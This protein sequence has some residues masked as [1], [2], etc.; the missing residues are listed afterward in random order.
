MSPARPQSRRIRILRDEVSRKIAAGEVID[1]PFSIVRELLDNAIDSGAKAIDVHIEAGGLGRVRV[2]DDGAGMDREDLALCWKP[3]ATSKIET[4]D[5]LLRVSSLGFRGEALSS[6]AVCSRL[7]I[8]SSQGGEEPA[9]R[10]EVQGGQG[11]APQPCQG[12]KGTVV[13]VAELF[14]NYPA[15]KKFLR[16]ASAESGLC[17]SIFIDRAIAF[18]AVAFRLYTDGDLK[19]SLPV[20]P[21]SE[22]IALAYSQF[23]DARGL[24]EGAEEG[25]G[26]RVRVVAGRPDLRRRDRKLLQC[27]VNGRRVSEFSLLQA[28]EYGFAGFIP[29]GWYPVAFIFVEIDPDLIDFNIHPAK[30]EVRFRN[31]PDFHKAVV[32]AVKR[33]VVPEGEPPIVIPARKAGIEFAPQSQRA[34]SL[35]LP[36]SPEGLPPSSSTGIRFLGQVFGVFLV[37]ELPG[38]LLVIDQHAAHERVIFE[39]LMARS[40]VLQEMLFPLVFDVSFEEEERLLG[41]LRD[42]EDLGIR[43]RRSGALTFEVTAISAELRPL[44]E[45]RLIELIR[46]VGGDEW[47]YSLRASAACRLAIKEGDRVDPVTAQELCARALELPVPRCPHGR[48]IWHELSRESLLR[49]VDR[50]LPEKNPPT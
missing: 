23:L 49:L 44:P 7:V 15:R 27:F 30:K 17:R 36:S 6:I 19:A 13:D 18:P 38:R 1:R 47:K 8:V 3:H 2:V 22:R 5:D 41:V 11:G 50:P 16:S 26:F 10:L 14:F 42:L 12:R 39:R 40:P 24:V 28:A 34:F 46:G 37:F 25:N 48:P 9:H 29:G 45:E 35:D 32:S 21:L 20:S 33:S 43:I 31:L 4:E